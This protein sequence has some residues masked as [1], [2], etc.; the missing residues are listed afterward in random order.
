MRDWPAVAEFWQKWHA[1]FTQMDGDLPELRLIRVP[2][3]RLQ[4]LW[5][6]LR[7]AAGSLEPGA[8]WREDEQREVSLEETPDAAALVAA[9]QVPF[10]HAL[11]REVRI[12]GEV[13][14]DLGVFVFPDEIALD[15]QPGRQWNVD[16]FVALLTL[17]H[18]LQRL[19]PGATVTTEEQMASEYR[20]AFERA[21]AEFSAR[22]AA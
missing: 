21:Y 13:L 12:R 9:G 4:P 1:T 15:Y 17:L 8:L 16:A 7:A 6:Y 19:A 2:G 11:L 5:E 10:F 20:E 14:P 3:D 22:N 18:Q